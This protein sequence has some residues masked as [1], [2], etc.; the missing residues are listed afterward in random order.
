MALTDT[1]KAAARKYLGYPDRYRETYY[2]LE[3][4]LDDLSAEGEVV[5]TGLLTSLASVDDKLESA[6]D[7]QK[8]TRAEEITLAGPGEIRALRAEGRRLTQ[9]LAAALNVEV[10]C[11]AFGGTSGSGIARRG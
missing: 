11:D 4:N 10:R 1:Q 5:V 8:V 9:R 3:A 7:R 6:W 2:R